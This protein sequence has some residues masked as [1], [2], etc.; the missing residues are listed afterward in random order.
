MLITHPHQQD[1][2]LWTVYRH[3]PNNFIERLTE[4]LLSN[5]TYPFSQCLAVLQGFLQ[6]VLEPCHILSLC[7]LMRNVLHEVLVVSSCPISRRDHVVEHIWVRMNYLLDLVSGPASFDCAQP[8]NNPLC[9]RSPRSMPRTLS[10][11]RVRLSNLRLTAGSLGFGLSHNASYI[12]LLIIDSNYV[13]PV[14]KHA[15]CDQ[16]HSPE[17][18]N[19]F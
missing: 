5:G 7:F 11:K 19:T 9:C 6:R 16:R 10:A 15:L 4:Q 13:H 3:L 14:A 8:S 12:N 1:T 2:S 18:N 17:F